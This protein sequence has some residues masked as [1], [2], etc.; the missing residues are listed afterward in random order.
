VTLADGEGRNVQADTVTI[1]DGA[2]AFTIAGQPVLL[3]AHT[4][5]RRCEAAP[6]PGRRPAGTRPDPSP[7][8]TGSRG[9]P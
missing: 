9:S 3:L 6:I 2:L 5:W 4:E 7:P 8:R 1:R